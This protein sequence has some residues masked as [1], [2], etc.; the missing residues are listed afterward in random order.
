MRQSLLASAVA[1]A[2]SAALGFTS[3]QPAAAQDVIKFGATAAL[4]GPFANVYGVQGKIWDAWAEA[5]NE[6]GGIFVKL[7]DKKLPVK[8]VYYDDQGDPRTSVKFYERLITEDK[9][10]FLLGPPGSPIAFAASTVA[11]RYKVPM[12]LGAATDAQIYA[13][14]FKYLQGTLVPAPGWSHQFMEMVKAQKTIHRVALLVEDSLYSRGVAIG[15]RKEA[16]SGDLSLVYDQTLPSDNQDFTAAID[17][18]K[19]AKPDLVY[20]STFPPFFIRFAKQAAELGLDPPALHCGTCSAT[21]IPGSLGPLAN[22]ITGEVVWAPGM[23]LGDYK[24]LE[25]TLQISGVDPVQW[26]FTVISIPVLEVLRAG[27]EKAGSLDREAV[28]NA[29]KTAEVDTTI[30]HF[31]ASSDGQGTLFPVPVQWQGGN[32]V[33]VWPPNAKTGEYIY[34]R[35]SK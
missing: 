2:L 6:E 13:R 32:L 28:F 35:Q 17:Q 29:I 22:G 7:S 30:G 15:I 3:M 1:A 9:V 24:L 19:E 21:S 26:T 5:Q 18:I 25:R 11:E 23:K 27:I 20:V 33:V 14:G 4:T 34:P 16:S 31:K 10:N 8:F 12:I